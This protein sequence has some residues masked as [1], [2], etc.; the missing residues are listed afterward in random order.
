[1]TVGTERRLRSM[2]RCGGEMVNLTARQAEVLEL[3]ICGLGDR[4]IARCLGISCRTVEHHLAA[5]RERTGTRNRA[6]L[7]AWAAVVGLIRDPELV[8]ARADSETREGRV[9]F[10][11]TTRPTSPSLNSLPARQFRDRIRDDVLVS[12]NDNS[13]R[14]GYAHVSTRP[15]DHQAQLDALAAA[16]CRVIIAE[17][18]S[19]RDGQPRLH[20]VLNTL[21]AGDTLVIHTP[22]RIARS[23][24][25]LLVLLRDELHARG[26]N[27]HILSGVCAGLHCPDGATMADKM[28]FLVAEMAAEMERDRTRE[29]SLNDLRV[30]RAQG[31]RSGRPRTLNRDKLAIARDR[32][33][34]GES[35]TTIA[36][37]LGIG[38]STL[39]R[40][41]RPPAHT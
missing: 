11:R 9:R 37:D 34:R 30:T 12:G 29:Q 23:V 7:T 17:T 18:A 41:F 5:L 13:V 6:E 31:R 20:R 25:E 38:R 2:L 27:L 26:I 35:V 10:R 1:M 21:R 3:V 14:V 36:R 4:Q 39:Y 32:R 24:N 22:D 16:N 40:A 8:P 33:L 15:Q 28:L 19:S